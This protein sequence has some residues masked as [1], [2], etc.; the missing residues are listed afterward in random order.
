M[1]KIIITLISAVLA[2]ALCSCD[3]GILTPATSAEPSSTRDHNTLP[4]I[5]TETQIPVTDTKEVTTEAET[6]PPVTEIGEYTVIDI[7]LAASK[8]SSG[9]LYIYSDGTYKAVLAMS[10]S[11]LGVASRSEITENGTCRSDDGVNLVCTVSQLSVKISF[12]NDA[13]RSDALE[14]LNYLQEIDA[15]SPEY[16]SS[17]EKAC[18]EEGL[19]ASTAEAASDPFLSTFVADTETKVF[20]DKEKSLAYDVTVKYDLP[21]GVYRIEEEGCVLTL[22]PNG[23]AGECS[24]DFSLYGD[25]G[26]GLGR[27][28]NSTVLKGTYVRNGDT[29]TCTIKGEL[30]VLRYDSAESQQA[31]LDALEEEYANGEIIEEV[32]NYNKATASEEG[33]YLD[34]GSDTDE[35]KLFVIDL[36]HAAVFTSTPSQEYE[37]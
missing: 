27:Y 11:E 3:P 7:A 23:N 24:L 33:R 18:G 13:D 31:Y 16:V 5:E 34:Y 2:L 30:T 17:Y 10:S 9:T 25:D 4:E 14:A 1:K 22:D 8:G 37:Q 35:Y 32:Y 15:V 6:E 36:T 28:T 21:D 29:V 20:L 26:D 19:S 12:D